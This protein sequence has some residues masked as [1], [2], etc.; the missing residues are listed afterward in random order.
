MLWINLDFFNFCYERYH[1]YEIYLI[2]AESIHRKTTEAI[3]KSDEHNDYNTP[4]F[5]VKG[6]HYKQNWIKFFKWN[7]QQINPNENVSF[8]KQQQKKIY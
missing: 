3:E 4:F 6:P 5:S 8:I 1:F 7:K 2:K